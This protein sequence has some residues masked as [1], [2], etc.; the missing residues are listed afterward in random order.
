LKIRSLDLPIAV[1]TMTTLADDSDLGFRIVSGVLDPAETSHLL[2]TLEASPLTRRA[3]G[4]IRRAVPGEIV[5]QLVRAELARDLASGRR[6]AVAETPRRAGV[7]FAYAQ[8]DAAGRHVDRRHSGR[9]RRG[10]C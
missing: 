2:R 8:G 3:P 5:R 1:R 7:G 10:G 9:L 4:T 6:I